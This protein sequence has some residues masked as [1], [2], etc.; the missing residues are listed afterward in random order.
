MNV[1]VIG[2]GLSG[3]TAAA[4]LAQAG[5]QVAVLSSTTALAA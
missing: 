2:S 1:V 3:L 5:H 4:Y